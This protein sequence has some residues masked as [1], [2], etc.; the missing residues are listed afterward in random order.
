MLKFRFEL[1]QQYRDFLSGFAAIVT[2][3]EMVD[4]GFESEVSRIAAVIP[5]ERHTSQCASYPLSYRLNEPLQ[6]LASM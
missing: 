6:P 3:S 2:A 1:L 4:L 5:S